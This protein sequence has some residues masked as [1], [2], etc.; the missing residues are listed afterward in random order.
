M[1]LASDT[2]T[3]RDFITL[4]LKEAGVL[5]VGQTALPEDINDGLTLLNRMFAQMQKKRWLVPSLYEVSAIGNNAKSNLIGPG[6]YYNAP[7]PDK[8]QAAYF[9]QI[10]NNGSNPVD[11]YL[12]TISSYEDYARVTLKELNSW[13]QFIFYDGAFPYGNVFI[14][15]IPSDQYEIHLVIKSPIGFTVMLEGGE[16]TNGGAAYT[17]GSYVAVPLTN[18]TGY[19]SGATADITVNGG[20]VTVVNVT[21]EASGDGF[22]IGDLLSA[23]AADIGGTGAGFIFKVTA[24]TDTL[25][26]DFNMPPE[27][28]EVIHYGLTKRLR[29]MYSM[30]P[31]ADQDGLYR[32]ALATIRQA[33]VQVPVLKMPSSLRNTRN[34]GP[35][36]IFNADAR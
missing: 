22:V 35:F 26:A 30:P 29:S 25:D 8:I 31:N 15:P 19:G 16:I 24:V 32:A 21:D 10:N 33:T 28:E 5:G 20:E 1:A 23:D 18:I 2:P 12:K 4:C 17:D 6:K 34:G 13:P 27:Y 7:R 11:F 9:R 3:A 14:W 36:Y